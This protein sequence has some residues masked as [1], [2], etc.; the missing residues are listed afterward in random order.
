LTSLAD[1]VAATRRAIALQDGPV[2]LAG[3]GK[4]QS[5]VLAYRT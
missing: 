5:R 4:S 2:L 3:C 1:D